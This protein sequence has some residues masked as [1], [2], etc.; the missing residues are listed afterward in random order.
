MADILNQFPSAQKSRDF[1]RGDV[2]KTPLT[3]NL[4][5][6]SLLDFLFCVLIA[7]LSFDFWHFVLF[8]HKT[9]GQS[10]S[11]NELSITET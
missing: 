7:D 4:V 3:P 2:Q 6:L 9:S 1:C 8:Y 10:G 11:N 5:R